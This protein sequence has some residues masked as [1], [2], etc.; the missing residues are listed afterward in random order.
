MPAG[1]ADTMPV[2]GRVVYQRFK[3]QYQCAGPDVVFFSTP[4]FHGMLCVVTSGLITDPNSMGF[5]R[6]TH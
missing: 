5:T 2:R 3:R 1:L 4:P 6:N